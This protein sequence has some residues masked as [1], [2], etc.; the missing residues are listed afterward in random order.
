M[1]IGAKPSSDLYL[2]TMRLSVILSDLVFVYA[3]HKLTK[4]LNQSWRFQVALYVN[5]GLILIDNMHFQYN[6]MMYGL[7]ILSIAYIYEGRLLK[8]ALLY[9]ILLN[10]KHIFL[11]SA[12]AYGLLYL[13]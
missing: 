3:C 7:M 6:S 13:R 11:Y 10:F 4:V 2:F 9:A 8:S 12:P 1:K 5:W